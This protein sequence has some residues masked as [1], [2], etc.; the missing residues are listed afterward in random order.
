MV[1]TRVKTGIVFFLI[2]AAFLVGSIWLPWLS[3]VLFALVAVLGALELSHALQKKFRPLSFVSIVIGSLTML[4]PVV[5]WVLYKD[6][7]QWHIISRD[8]LPLDARWPSD[9]IWL[10]AFGFLAFGLA[11]G[12][13][14]LLNVLFKVLSRGPE[15]M[16]HAVAESS[17]AFYI[18]FPLTAVVL[19]A[20]AVPNGYF[21][22]LFAVLTPMVVDVAAYYSGSLLGKRK[23][24]PKVSP[25]KTWVGF[26]GGVFAGVVFGSAIF[27]I[28]FTGS[29][30]M[31]PLTQSVVFGGAAGLLLGL[32]AQFG[33][34]IASSLKRWCQIKDFSNLLPGHGGIMDRFDSALYTLPTTLVLA[35]VFFLLERVN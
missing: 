33:D 9:F 12:V 26:F 2:V 27:M 30:P 24:L 34:W 4:A 23:M 25:N 10:L 3:V 32:T 31:L 6:L 29:Q 21:W 17:A 19:F 5:V 14:A 11:F 20:F 16:P 13:Y 15:H 8:S 28:F 18:A 1:N 22:L 35:L 7:R